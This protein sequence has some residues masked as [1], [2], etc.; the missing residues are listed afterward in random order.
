MTTENLSDFLRDRVMPTRETHHVQYPLDTQD[1]AVGIIIDC[2]EDATTAVILPTFARGVLHLELHFFADGERM[3][4]T[5]NIPEPP[6][7]GC[8]ELTLRKP[9][10]ILE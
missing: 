1:P 2:S 4:P 3:P 10:L 5:I 6:E 8:V 9:E 7:D